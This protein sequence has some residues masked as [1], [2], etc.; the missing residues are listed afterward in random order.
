MQQTTSKTLGIA[1]AAAL[2]TGLMATS[3]DAKAN[4]VQVIIEIPVNPFSQ[5][6]DQNDLSWLR[7][8]QQDFAIV[9]TWESGHRRF[10]LRRL[11]PKEKTKFLKQAQPADRHSYAKDYTQV[12]A[13]LT[14]LVAKL[15]RGLIAF[16]DTAAAD[17]AALPFVFGEFKV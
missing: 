14:E 3:Q 8:L 15:D 13:I 7:F 1:A 16:L 11:L 10:L 9:T 4:L 5:I 6:A 2:T 12:P 17:P